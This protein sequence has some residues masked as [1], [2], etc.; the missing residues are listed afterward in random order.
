MRRVAG[1]SPEG[2][3]AR[4]GS[5]KAVVFCNAV[6]QLAWRRRTARPS[7]PE[8]IILGNALASQTQ[9]AG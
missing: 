2:M 5:Q 3:P 6:W 4:R 9:V 7:G 8:E 1:N